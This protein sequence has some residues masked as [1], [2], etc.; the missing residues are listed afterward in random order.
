M[1]MYIANNLSAMTAHG[2]M[3]TNDA[4]MSTAI[5]RLSSGFKINS[6]ADNAAGYVVS[7]SLQTDVMGLQQSTTNTTNAVNMVKTALDAVNQQESSLQTIRN[8]VLDASNNVGN[9][10]ALAGDQAQIDQSVTAINRVAT[11]TQFDGIQLLNTGTGNNVN[12]RSFQLG[13]QTGQ[14]VTFNLPTTFEGTAISGDMTALSLG[15][16]QSAGG[17][18]PSA[19]ASAAYTAGASATKTNFLNLSYTHA[20]GT[21]QQVVATFAG[22]STL[23]QAVTAINASI[24]GALGAGTAVDTNVNGF[25]ATT[26]A[27]GTKLVIRA[28]TANTADQS[29]TAKVNVVG[30]SNDTTVTGFEAGQTDA[31][32]ANTTRLIDVTAGGANYDNYLTIIDAALKKV[33]GLSVNLG[34]FQSN[35]LQSNL[36]Q[37]SVTT[38][39]L[40]DSQAAIKDTDMAST[41]VQYT[42]SNILQQAAQAMMTQANTS[43]NNIIQMLRG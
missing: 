34:A 42:Q 7:Q 14:S 43:S 40:Q 5:E 27:G 6:A 13:D 2:Y 35:N 24:N 25:L 17:A 26:D 3:Q 28:A 15:L 41:M 16:T 9:A 31:G 38:Q 33:N 22:N 30:Y 4:N 36:N 11:Q 21:T 23:A 37:L 18:G 19:T 39:N 8:L 1:S 32:T 20:N 29:A 12:G 10:D